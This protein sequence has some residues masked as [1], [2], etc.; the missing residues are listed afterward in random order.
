M[1]EGWAMPTI[2]P[3]R[4]FHY[5]RNGRSLCGKYFYFGETGLRKTVEY[6]D[7]KCKKCLKKLRKENRRKQ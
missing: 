6:E 5:I 4:K 7:L 1:E 2:P 3:A